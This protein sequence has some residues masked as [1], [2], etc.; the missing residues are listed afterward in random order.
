MFTK[1]R[2]RALGQRLIQGRSSGERYLGRNM[3]MIYVA[4]MV[5]GIL[6]VHNYAHL[7]SVKGSILPLTTARNGLHL[8]IYLC[9]VPNLGCF[10][11]LRNIYLMHYLERHKHF[12]L[13]LA[14]ALKSDKIIYTYE[15]QQLKC[16]FKGKLDQKNTLKASKHPHIE[17][18]T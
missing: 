15:T 5:Q 9:T 14:Q 8:S 10:S 7:H 2:T 13:G 4:A 12:F 16:F 17:R 3:D 18:Q 11:Q 6:E 1:D